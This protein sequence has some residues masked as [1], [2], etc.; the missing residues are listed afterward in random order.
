LFRHFQNF[1]R[2]GPE[3][4]S[5]ATEATFYQPRPT[6][7]GGGSLISASPVGSDIVG[8]SMLG[9]RQRAKKMP[10]SR[11]LHI[12]LLESR[13]APAILFAK[14]LDLGAPAYGHG[15]QTRPGQQKVAEN[16]V[17]AA[18][19]EADAITFYGSLYNDPGNTASFSIMFFIDS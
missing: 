9:S 19:G 15:S 10:R 2:S 14:P 1:S 3:S 4:V 18:P 5:W 16:F 7:W 13:L 17:L 6:Y 11:Q 12:E 8:G